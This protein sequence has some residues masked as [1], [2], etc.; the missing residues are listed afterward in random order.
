MN[1]EVIQKLRDWRAR[2]AQKENIELFRIF[3]NKTLEDFA[4]ILPGNK[5]ELLAIKGIILFV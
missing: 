1:Q 2:K 3:Q 5:D 4:T